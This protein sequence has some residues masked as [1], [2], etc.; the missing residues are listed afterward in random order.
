[1]PAD[2]LM[3]APLSLAGL[4][5]A[6]LGLAASPAAAQLSVAPAD[7]QGIVQDRLNSQQMTPPPELRTSLAPPQ[8]TAPAAGQPPAWLIIPRLGVQEEI[9]DN[10]RQSSTQRTA[11][12]V[13]MISPGIFISG[14]TPALRTTIDY[15]PTFQRN[16]V[17]TD[18]NAIYQQG[19]ATADATLLPEHLFLDARASAFL[20]SRTGGD[21]PFNAATLPQSERTQVIAYSGGPVAKM[22]VFDEGTAELRYT[23]GQTQFVSN[24]GALS[25]GTT[26]STVNSVSSATTQDLRANIDSGESFGRIENRLILDVSRSDVADSNFSSKAAF[27]SDETQYK[28]RSN[29]ALIG[30]LGYQL[31]RFPGYAAADENGAIAMGG[32]KYTPNPDSYLRVTYGHHDGINSFQ[33]DGRY[34]VTPL[35]TVFASYID[36]ITTPQQ[37]ILGNL[38]TAAETADGTIVNS[39]TGLPASL[40]NSQFALQNDILRFGTLTG[41]ITANLNPNIFTL[42]LVQ[43]TIQSLTGATPNDSSL[44][45]NIGWT[46]LMTPTTN[47]TAAAGYYVHDVNHETSLDASLTLTHNF[48]ETL[49]GSVRYEFAKID[50]DEP[51]I[52]FYQ[53]LMTVSMRKLF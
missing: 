29:F 21:A 3:L 50:S 24:S 32:F 22:R 17:A 33:G 53:N 25:S 13:S 42:T 6:A 9:T 11:D 47:L 43:Q 18:Q 37:A 26:A 48:T 14:D 39:T 30:D 1:M 38:A 4:C 16:V 31:Y 20:G 51:G 36:S 34:A 35:T 40:Y 49:F 46:R 44:G 15:S 41:G 45:G 28:L 23:I 27:V 5:L 2:R 12:F 8:A 7:E 19:F 10:A 52:S